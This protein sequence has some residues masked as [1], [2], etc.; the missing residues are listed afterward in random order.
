VA[1][2]AIAIF[3]YL[4]SRAAKESAEATKTSVN[5]MDKT[6]KAQIV[7][8]VTE[9]YS[10]P[11]MLSSML[12]IIDWKKKYPDQGETFKNL[13]E[14]DYDRVK[15]VDIARRRFSHHLHGIFKL[16][17]MGIVENDEAIKLADKGKADFWFEFV[18]DLE[19]QIEKYKSFLSDFLSEIHNKNLKKWR[20]EVKGRISKP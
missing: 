17:E 5:Q 12:K 20:E 10:S 8:Q 16:K 18:E 3:S 11:E 13:R 9:Q 14:K 1:T 7:M 15:D 19:K 2:I 4:S 6:L